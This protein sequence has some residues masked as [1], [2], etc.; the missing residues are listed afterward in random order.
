MTWD[1]VVLLAA[2]ACGG[3]RTPVATDGPGR[4]ETYRCGSIQFTQQEVE[5]APAATDLD[6]DARGALEGIEVPP[7]DPEDDWLVLSATDIELALVRELEQPQDNGPGDVRTHEFVHAQTRQ[8]ATD[9]PEGAWMSRR[10]GRVRHG[11]SSTGSGK[12]IS[13]C[14]RHPKRT[15][16]KSTS[17]CTSVRAR[18][19]VPFARRVK[20]AFNG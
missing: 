10:Q 14:R 15:R 6:E 19:G 13:Y 4:A 17:T 12:P 5:E 2:V 20:I 18:P 7:I 1:V 11:L 8:G 3:S 9:M 16:R